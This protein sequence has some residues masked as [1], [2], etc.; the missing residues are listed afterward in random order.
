MQSKKDCSND[1]FYVYQLLLVFLV[2]ELTSEEAIQKMLILLIYLVPI[3]LQ[4]FSFLYL[5]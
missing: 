3:D 4:S 1:Y 5:N 2:L